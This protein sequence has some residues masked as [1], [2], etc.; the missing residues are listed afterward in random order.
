MLKDM[1]NTG[2]VFRHGFKG[3][4]KRIFSIAVADV[5]MFGTGTRML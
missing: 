3:N 5:D 4:A 1:G 2:G